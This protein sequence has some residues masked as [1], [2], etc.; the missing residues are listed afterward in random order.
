MKSFCRALILSLTWSASIPRVCSA[1]PFS[2]VFFRLKASASASCYR[3]DSTSNLGKPESLMGKDGVP[4][5]VLVQFNVTSSGQDQQFWDAESRACCIVTAHIKVVIGISLLNKG[6]VFS[7]EAV[8]Q[9]NCS[10]KHL[11]QPHSCPEEPSTVPCPSVFP[12]VTVVPEPEP[13]L[14]TYEI[15]ADA[16]G[17]CEIWRKR[18]PHALTQITAIESPLIYVGILS[19]QYGAQL[20]TDFVHSLSDRRVIVRYISP[21]NDDYIVSLQIRQRGE[22]QPTWAP[23][24]KPCC[25]AFMLAYV[26]LG[27]ARRSFTLLSEPRFFVACPPHPL[28]MHVST[29]NVEYELP[30]EYVCHNVQSRIEGRALEGALAQG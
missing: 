18:W 25:S 28:I 8:A 14:Q 30:A 9:M 26:G 1:S 22:Y 20:W 4:E 24:E 5:K 10:G 2:L 15:E 12:Q 27:V 16:S 29:C 3:N 6:K 11:P 19:K 17:H 21:L 13:V 23:P 7:A